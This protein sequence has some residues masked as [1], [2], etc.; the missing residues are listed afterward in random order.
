MGSCD[1]L[2][3]PLGE[4]ITTFNLKDAVCNHGF[5]M[6]TLNSWIPST[7]TLQRPLGHANSTT[8]VMVSISQPPN[9]S[10]I[11]IQVHDIQNTL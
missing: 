8:S 11:L 7:K 4:C 3:L 1:L 2:H 5:S 10:S 6:M 9:S